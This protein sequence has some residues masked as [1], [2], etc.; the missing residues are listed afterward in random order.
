[1]N[2]VTL[3]IKD[4]SGNFQQA[5]LFDD[6]N[7]SV[8]SKIQD[9]RDISKIFTDF[10]QSFTIPASKK[11]NKTFSHFYNYFITDGG[12][13][14]RKRVD[15]KLEINYIPFREGKIALNGVK[16]KNN[17][18]YAY[19]TTFFGNTVNLKDVLGDDQLESLGFL[20]EF[21]Y[22]YDDTQ[23]KTRFSSVVDVTVNSVS[24]LQ[25]IIV[26]LITPEK[27]LF[28]NSSN[29]D[30]NTLSGNISYDAASPVRG[31]TFTDLKP[32]I[33]LIYI[34]EAIEQKYPSIQF[35]RDFFDTEAFSGDGATNRGLYM[36]LS[37]EK[38]IIGSG[39][40]NK[41]N[42][43]SGFSYTSGTAIASFPNNGTAFSFSNLGVNDDSVLNVEQWISGN[44]FDNYRIE[45]SF[46][47]SVTTST[48]SVPYTV[49]M[50]DTLNNNEVLGEFSNQTGNQ[51][52]VFDALEI[53]TRRT[54]GLQWSLITDGSFVGASALTIT[55]N[56]KYGYLTV[57]TTAV[58]TPSSITPA[59]S[60]VPTQR[61]P[62]MKIIDFLSSIFKMFN[63]T[64][65]VI[66]DRSDSDYGKIK[67]MDLNS[68]YNDSPAIFDI[69]KYTETSELDIETTI[70]FTELN[71]EYEEPSTLLSLQHNEKFND[72]FGNAEYKPSNVDRGDNPYEVKAGFEHLKFERLVDENDGTTLTDI[73]WGYSAGDNFKPDADVDPKTG[74]YESVLT[75]PLLFY[76]I[77]VTGLAGDKGISW[78]AGGSTSEL[79]TYWR[80]SNTCENGS[81]ST[82]AA[83]TINFDNE[84]DEWNLTDY[85]GSTNSLFSKFY[86]SYVE[87]IFDPRKRIFKVTAHLPNS[88]LLNYEL[89]DRFQIGDKV[90][91]INSINTNLK[92]GKSQLELLNVL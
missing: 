79:S 35:T 8:T 27:R 16:M 74:N 89:N 23:T 78:L 92:T 58:Y 3:Y 63:L 15:A 55:Q 53:R 66:S 87:D 45:Y 25:P 70:P 61:I 31:V 4:S 37:R 44:K 82:A 11:N 19:N 17:K 26:P 76:G 47:L 68:Y 39:D 10:S 77:R 21:T 9:I 65:Y 29:N 64:A 12:F 33:R 24:K 7:I 83:F 67:V 75:K 56:K 41:E 1:M 80:P 38:G 81:L 52:L 13:D 30:S 54:Y 84:K 72:I 51:T 90:F 6:E 49:R 22:D 50:I 86:R 28:F 88:V 34:I 5:D 59:A 14:S 57:I 85:G 71:F 69:S 32:A 36:W 91:T 46:S 40:D 60:I 18:P 2:R 20:D 42:I 48:A 73:L 43:L 62:K